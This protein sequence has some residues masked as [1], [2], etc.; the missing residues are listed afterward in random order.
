MSGM[1]RFLFGLM[2]L[3]MLTP[4]LACAMTFCPM[5]KTQSSEM[6]CHQSD[7]GNG[8]PMLV[9]DCMG[10]DLFQQDVS[11]DFQPNQSFEKIDYVSID[12]FALQN[13]FQMKANEIRGPPEWYEPTSLTDQSL[14][15]TT[16][17]LRI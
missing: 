8:L 16:R 5:Q 9:L 12:I 17:R 3:A 13:S 14:F 15:L 7:D 4:S 6:P 11:Y 1:K 10:V 2:L